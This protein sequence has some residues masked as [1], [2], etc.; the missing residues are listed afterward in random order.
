M[1]QYAELLDGLSLD[2]WEKSWRDREVEFTND[3][4]SRAVL[5]QKWDEGWGVLSE[6][7]KSL[8]E[9]DLS[10]TIYI[11]NQGHSVLD[12]INRQSAHYPYHIG[13]L[14]FLGK[15][16]AQIWTSLSIPKGGSEQYNA[17]KFTQ[18]KCK[19]HFTDEYLMSDMPVEKNG[20]ATDSIL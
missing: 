2:R 9:E 18:P 8:Q 6:T 10:K 1:G 4:Q 13:K 12:A 20:L 15:M 7:L 17:Q 14:V 19:A 3:I 16:L 5:L 11:R